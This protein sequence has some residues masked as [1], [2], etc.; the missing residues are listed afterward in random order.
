MLWLRV[1][2]CW[3]EKLL[4]LGRRLQANRSWQIR[5]WLWALYKFY[6][7]SPR[8]GLWG[9]A[10]K[11]R[12]RDSRPRGRRGIS[13][14]NRGNPRFWRDKF[15][16]LIGSLGFQTAGDFG[17]CVCDYRWLID[18]G[19]C[20]LR[21]ICPM[22]MDLRERI[23]E[24]SLELVLDNLDLSLS[25]DSVELDYWRCLALGKGHCNSILS[26]VYNPLRVHMDNHYSAC[27]VVGTKRCMALGTK[28]CY[29]CLVLGN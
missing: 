8:V 26:M 6:L 17:Y 27:M 23:H 3:G 19:R 13:K 28:R 10:W 1:V 21:T 25:R 4:C 18:N 2:G 20:R 16:N 24:Q 14:T 9:W 29:R 7:H 11:F 15:W 22:V 5:I 12:A